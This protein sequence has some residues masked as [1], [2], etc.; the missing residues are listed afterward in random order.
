[1][2]TDTKKHFGSITKILHWLIA[3]V[4]FSLFGVGLW[5]VEL[6]YYSPYYKTVP[7]LHRSIGV[8]VGICMFLRLVW[9]LFNQTPEPVKGLPKWQT[10]IAHIVHLLLYLLV[11][12]ICFSG[13]LISTADGRSVSV[14]GLI[15]IPATITSIDNQEDIA[16]L[17][18][19]YFAVAIIGL[20]VLHATAALKHHFINKNETLKRMLPFSKEP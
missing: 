19:F 8:V 10:H 18:H 13:Y 16:G 17:L 12:L 15:D 20:A 7:D 6:T 4:I 1:M 2:L 11:F 9:R 5:M 14:F 3:L